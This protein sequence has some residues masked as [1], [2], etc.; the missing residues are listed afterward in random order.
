VSRYPFK[1]KADDLMSRRAGTI[2]EST[3]NGLVR[4]YTRMERDFILLYSDKRVSTL[5]PSKFTVDDVRE[6]LT[7]R[8]G[9]KVSASDLGHDISALKDLCEFC[10]N[11][12]VSKCLAQNPG[13]KPKKK[14][15]RLDPLPYQNYLRILDK[16]EKIS[17][18]DFRRLRTYT[19]VLMYICTG[20]R[21]K[22]LRLAK[23]SDLDTGRWEI[24][25][26]HV[27]GE[28]SYGHPRTVPIPEAIRPLIKDYLMARDFWLFKN[29]TSSEALFFAFNETHGFMSGNSIRKAKKLIEQDLG[30]QFEIRDCRRAFGQYYLNNG[31]EIDSVSVLMGHSSTKTTEGYYCRKREE[32]AIKAV[33][34]RWQ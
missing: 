7:Y 16:S 15:E 8:R 24:Y 4:R 26:E 2:V 33:K 11:T 23:V 25:Y 30:I 14:N 10:D 3:Y 20:A 27:K 18:D 17:R 29:R 1:E 13:L 31:V 12:C 6:F 19:L 32:D 22:E 21:N 9:K 34:N 5:A 28:E